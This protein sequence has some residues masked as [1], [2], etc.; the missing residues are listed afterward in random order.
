MS[1]LLDESTIGVFVGLVI[2]GYV[3]ARWGIHWWTPIA[4]L[5][6][7]VLGHLIWLSIKEVL[8]G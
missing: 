8:G 3:G 2:G 6:S 1:K 7:S 4:A 5:V